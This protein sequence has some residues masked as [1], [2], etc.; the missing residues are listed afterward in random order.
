MPKGFIVLS[1]TGGKDTRQW[2][3]S[4]TTALQ[5]KRPAD[6][7][8]RAETLPFSDGWDSSPHRW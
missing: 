1:G 7:S 3:P 4:A 2:D 5:L 8:A 6:V